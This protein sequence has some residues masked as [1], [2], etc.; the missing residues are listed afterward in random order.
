M[1]AL[2]DGKAAVEG[3]TGPQRPGE[4]VG[5]SLNTMCIASSCSGR[6]GAH[7]PRTAVWGQEKPPEKLHQPQFFPSGRRYEVNGT[8][9][10]AARLSI[11]STRWWRDLDPVLKQLL[12]R[13]LGKGQDPNE[14]IP[15]LRQAWG[16]NSDNELICKLAGPALKIPAFTKEKRNWGRR[17][18]PQTSTRILEEAGLRAEG[19]PAYVDLELKRRFLAGMMRVKSD[20]KHLNSKQCA[21]RLLREKLL[22]GW[23]NPFLVARSVPHKE[24]K[25]LA[26]YFADKFS[27]R[28]K[29]N[30]QAEIIA[31]EM[32]EEW[33]EFRSYEPLISELI[34]F[35][36]YSYTLDG[37][38][39][40]IW[41]HLLINCEMHS[42]M[43]QVVTTIFERANERDLRVNIRIQFCVIRNNRVIKVLTTRRLPSFTDVTKLMAVPGAQVEFEWGLFI[44][45]YAQP[46]RLQ[47]RLRGP[48]DAYTIYR[49]L[50]LC[51]ECKDLELVVLSAKEISLKR[52]KD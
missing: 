6:G 39:S 21:E 48:A 28:G 41:S 30:D 36:F 44:D 18:R 25:R 24:V 11:T 23:P 40:V 10:G 22:L 15:V 38:P 52:R 46:D 47:F 37:D 13:P 43:A 27:H 7:P 31:R 29:L 3:R 17:G 35:Y 19:I 49:L 1:A 2:N 42:A 50:K 33:P 9:Y 12:E 4:P 34:P 8:I 45:G 14:M 16:V 26:A 5:S 20:H 32:E 51:P